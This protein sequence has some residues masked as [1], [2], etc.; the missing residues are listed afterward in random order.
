MTKEE[1]LL[2]EYTK[3]LQNKCVSV[4]AES[5]D[6]MVGT[7]I[8]ENPYLTNQKQVSDE[9]IEMQAKRES[10]YNKNEPT[11]N[12]HRDYVSFKLGAKWMRDKLTK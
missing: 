5:V 11:H 3:W 7:F 10:A 8:K 4:N 6:N 2:R 9:E 1:K 12:S